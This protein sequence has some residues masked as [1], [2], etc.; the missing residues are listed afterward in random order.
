[1]KTRQDS[2]NKKL[3]GTFCGKLRR[4]GFRAC[5]VSEVCRRVG[6]VTEVERN[7]SSEPVLRK[8]VAEL[9]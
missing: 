5:H 8:L 4:L 6:E 7:G 9:R 3:H 2:F 1:V